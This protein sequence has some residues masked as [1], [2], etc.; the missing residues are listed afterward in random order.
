MSIVIEMGMAGG[1][2][3]VG[4][5]ET[6]VIEQ[7]WKMWKEKKLKEERL[8]WS[9]NFILYRI[10]NLKVSLLVVTATQYT[11]KFYLKIFST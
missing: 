1:G 4:E 6:T 5:R 10:K 11:L 7:Q 9:S 2:G 8:A 3:V